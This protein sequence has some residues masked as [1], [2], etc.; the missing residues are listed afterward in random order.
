[1]FIILLLFFSRSLWSAPVPDEDDLLA[2]NSLNNDEFTPD[3][4]PFAFDDFAQ[5]QKNQALQFDRWDITNKR[6]GNQTFNFEQLNDDIFPSSLGDFSTALFT[7]INTRN[8]SNTFQ[9]D[10]ESTIVAVH[11]NGNLHITSAY[12]QDVFMG[13]SSPR[14]RFSTYTGNGT[15]TSHL[16][17]LGNFGQAISVDPYLVVNGLSSGVAPKRKFWLVYSSK[18]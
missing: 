4:I 18:I 12:I 15:P 17:P 11:L 1:L 16:L 10:Y 13:D 5:D 9:Q 3:P 7:L 2:M 8:V 6:K 14:I